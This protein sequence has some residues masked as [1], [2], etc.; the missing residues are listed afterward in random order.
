MKEEDFMFQSP[1][2]NKIRNNNNSTSTSSSMVRNFPSNT[3]STAKTIYLIRHGESLGQKADS[4][5]ARRNDK[6]LI[7]CGLSKLGMWQAE[8]QIRNLL[9]EEEMNSIE[10]VVS[11]PLTRAIQT[12]VLA[13]PDKPILIHY[14]LREVG[15]LIPEN[16]PRPMKQVFDDLDI[17][18]TVYN[19]IDYS[20]Y[21][22]DNWPKNHDVTP[23]VVRNDRIRNVFQSVIATRPER[24]IAVICHYHVIR[25]A[26][27][28]PTFSS[29]ASP[30]K[31]NLVMEKTTKGR[32]NHTSLIS[33]ISNRGSASPAA[34]KTVPTTTAT[35]QKCTSI[36]RSSLDPERHTTI[37]SSPMTKTPTKQKI[38]IRPMNATPIKCFLDVETGQLS[39]SNT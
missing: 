1:E 26:L 13:F 11:S 38:D 20:T 33:S 29:F 32:S 31:L 4:E 12:A 2:G 9:T 34:T 3:S 39:L 21:Q 28:N 18:P 27:C 36:V 14:D 23:K 7:D 15:T 30:K 35:P 22:P 37:R 16:I 5:V 8:V 25:S 24:I 17:P 19:N 10:L 6:N